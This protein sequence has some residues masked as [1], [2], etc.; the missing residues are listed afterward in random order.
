MRILPSCFFTTSLSLPDI[1]HSIPWLIVLMTR[2]LPHTYPNSEP[3]STATAATRVILQPRL[4]R[5]PSTLVHC[6]YCGW[7]KLRLQVLSTWEFRS[8]TIMYVFT[9]WMLVE[10]ILQVR[11]SFTLFVH[12]FDAKLFLLWILNAQRHLRWCLAG[13]LLDFLWSQL[14]NGRWVVI[15]LVICNWKTTKL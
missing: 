11:S 13:L 10:C 6:R 15:V 2:L 3:V 7:V 8:R 14:T 1:K 9:V 5:C 12:V 4:W